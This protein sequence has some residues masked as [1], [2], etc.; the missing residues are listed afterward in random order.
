ML[1]Y[2]GLISLWCYCFQSQYW[3]DGGDY[4]MGYVPI[5]D[6]PFMCVRELS[7]DCFGMLFQYVKEHR[8]GCVPE[9]LQLYP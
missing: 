8:Q 4:A 6:A 1:V 2:S 3:E 5:V 9:V 7:M